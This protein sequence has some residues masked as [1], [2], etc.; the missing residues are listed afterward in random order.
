MI[1]VPRLP[2]RPQPTDPTAKLVLEWAEVIFYIFGLVVSAT[3]LV[4]SLVHYIPAVL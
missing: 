1:V 3:V 4:L 2:R